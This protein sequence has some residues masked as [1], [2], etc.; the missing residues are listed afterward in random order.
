L[1]HQ[2]HD[3][4]PE[5]REFIR[6]RAAVGRRTDVLDEAIRRL[7]KGFSFSPKNADGFKWAPIRRGIE[8]FEKA[9]LDPDATGEL[10]VEMINSAVRSLRQVGDFV[11]LVDAIYAMMKM[12]DDL[13]PAMTEPGRAAI[14]KRLSEAAAFAAGKF[15][16]GVSN[17]L[18]ALAQAWTRADA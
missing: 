11:P 8:Q 10:L 1:L 3:A 6:A 16:Y 12:L 18:A 17:E 2:L 5:A 9:T 13:R 15:G 7:A 14:G 4:I